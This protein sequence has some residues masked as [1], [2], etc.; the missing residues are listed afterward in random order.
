MSDEHDRTCSGWRLL[1]LNAGRTWRRLIRWSGFRGKT[2]WQW[3][4]LLIVPLMIAA[5]S[6]GF[7]PFELWREDQ[8]AL[9]QRQFEDDRIRQAVLQSYIRDMTEVLLD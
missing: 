1:R 7:G 3:L 5:A 9:A 8:R 2:V 4:E 6:L